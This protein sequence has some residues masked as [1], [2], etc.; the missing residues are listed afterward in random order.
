MKKSLSNRYQRV[1]LLPLGTQTF[2]YVLHHLQAPPGL[3]KTFWIKIYIGRMLGGFY[4]IVCQRMKQIKWWK[5]SIKVIMEVIFS[6]RL[7]NKV[8]RVGFYWPTLFVDVHKRVCTCHQCQIFER[9]NK[10][11]PLYLK[12]ISVEVPCQQWGLDFIGEIH[13]STSTQQKWILTVIYYFTK[14]IEE[15]PI[16]QA[17][18][19][20]II[21]FMESNI[22]SRFGCPHKIITDN[23]VSFKSKN[24]VD[25]CNIYHIVLWHSTSYYSQG[26]GLVES[27][28]KSLVN[29]I[30]KVLQEN[31]KSWHKKL[32]NALWANRVSTKKS[33]GMSPFQLVYGVDA[34][35]PTSLGILVLKILQKLEVESNDVQRRINQMVQLQQ[36]REEVYYNTRI[37]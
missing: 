4:W 32:I 24:M 12:P 2:F 18:D 19:W 28:N 10:L 25:F 23:V 17:I 22:L 14:W 6:G 26:N 9:K 20:V 21:Q 8:L 34:V 5:S 11:L 13:P 29:I 30:K 37:I 36:T 1:L 3:T 15:V 35:F 7:Q 31:K 33:I 27:S 16:R